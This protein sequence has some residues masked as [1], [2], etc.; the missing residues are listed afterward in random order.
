MDT[1]IL[2]SRIIPKLDARLRDDPR[3]SQYIG[4]TV[5]DKTNEWL[6]RAVRIGPLAYFESKDQ[7]TNVVRFIAKFATEMLS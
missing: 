2:W 6:V 4:P 1:G 5:D 7:E 3:V